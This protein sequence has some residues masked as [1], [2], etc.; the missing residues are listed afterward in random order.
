MLKRKRSPN[1]GKWSP[2]GGKLNMEDGESPFE[3]AIREAREETGMLLS[4]T[5]LHLFG[6]VSEKCY[7]NSGHWLMFLFDCKK[8]IQKLPASFDEGFFEFFDEK[9]IKDLD[10]PESDHDL[11]WP[12]YFKRGERFWGLRAEWIDGK[13][14]IKIEAKA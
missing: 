3:C 6:Y 7:E 14:K 13:V 5:D 10:I 8:E 4:E 2:P 9:S 11:V 12:Y 1:I